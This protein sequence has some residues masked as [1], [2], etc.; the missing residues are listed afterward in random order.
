VEK[1]GG[2]FRLTENALK[3][4]SL[5]LPESLTAR[6]GK[7][8]DPSPLRVLGEILDNGLRRTL[9]RNLR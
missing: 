1:N 6:Q 3:S 9:G 4:E 2:K 5:V 7:D 8:K